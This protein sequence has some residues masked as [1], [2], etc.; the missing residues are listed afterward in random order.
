VHPQHVQEAL[1]KSRARRAQ[2][3]CGTCR[4]LQA[5]LPDNAALDRVLDLAGYTRADTR[6]GSLVRT[7]V[8]ARASAA[9]AS[10]ARASAA[11]ASAARASAARASAARASAGAGGASASDGAGGASASDGAGGASAS[12]GDARVGTRVGRWSSDEV[13]V[14]IKGL[15]ATGSS[16]ARRISKEIAARWHDVDP[17]LWKSARDYLQ[18]TARATAGGVGMAAALALYVLDVH[19]VGGVSFGQKRPLTCTCICT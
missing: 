2:A 15:R 12:A 1:Q 6:A 10:A 13:D 7:R 18:I 19:E 3:E 5:E 4:Q 9:R 16:G 14:V 8:G 11:R 17:A